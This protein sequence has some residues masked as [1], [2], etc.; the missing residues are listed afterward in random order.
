MG[1]LARMQAATSAREVALKAEIERVSE[2][3]AARDAEL[4]SLRGGEDP[5]ENSPPQTKPPVAPQQPVQELETAS[6]DPDPPMPPATATASQSEPPGS[7]EWKV[8]FR[9]SR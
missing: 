3:L 6:A 5:G 8:P 7:S 2:L 1:A 4:A 9:M